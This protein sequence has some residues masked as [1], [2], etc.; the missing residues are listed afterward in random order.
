MTRTS[1]RFVT[2]SERNEILR[3]HERRTALNELLLVLVSP[4][5]STNERDTLEVEI[6]EDL[7]R[8]NALFEAWWQD[9]GERYHLESAEHGRWSI[10]F[11]SREL[12]FER[13]LEEC[14]RSRSPE[15]QTPSHA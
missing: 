15:C 13:A 14:C 2:P 9:V 8:T 7:I 5:L 1:T 6:H 10:D 3:L 12:S 11:E 4:Y